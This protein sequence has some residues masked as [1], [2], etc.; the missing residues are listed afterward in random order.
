MNRINA[1]IMIYENAGC[2]E[3]ADVY[4]AIRDACRR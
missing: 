1:R 2:K 3:L 4:R